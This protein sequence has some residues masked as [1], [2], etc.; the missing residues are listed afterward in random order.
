MS[1]QNGT[2][3]LGD[4][5][6]QGRVARLEKAKRVGRT[7]RFQL[8]PFVQLKPST[9]PDYLVKGL[10]PRVG[11]TVIWG[12]PK[13]GKS[14]I[15]SD[16]MMSVALGWEFR[17]RKVIQGAVVYC[18]F[19]GADGFG[20]RAEAFRQHHGLAE[21]LYVPFYLVS[22]RM[23]FIK[24]HIEL[25]AAIRLVLG[26]IKPVAVVLDTLHRSLA[27]SESNDEDMAKY[28]KAVDALREELNCAVVVAHHCGIDASRPRGHSSLTGA[29]DAQLAIKR[30]S[31]NHIVL[32][33]ER[34]KDG[35]EGDTLLSRLQ[36][37]MVGLD[38]DG[39]PI[40][41]CV[42]LPVD[43]E[44]LRAPAARPTARLS[45]AAQIALLALE[46][47]LHHVRAAGPASAHIH[48]E[49]HIVTKSQWRQFAYRRGISGSKK[50][51]AQQQAF[52]R[53][54]EQLIGRG[55]VSARGEQ[56]WRTD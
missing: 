3:T 14:F 52:Q 55:I 47:A 22:A 24:D 46:D 35:P 41:S 42:V 2:K 1:E 21:D 26:N 37:V 32:K 38:E 7:P 44:P 10:I 19:E 54:S 6:E 20:K 48:A 51:R 45:K 15:I 28:V 23:D 17:E 49:T 27:G 12:P 8:V 31:A 9:A 50:D 18:A 39:D 53:A 30:A 43:S 4:K 29:V 56:V 36:A 13:S 16:L 11:L 5:I 40:T 25:L 34:M 33:V